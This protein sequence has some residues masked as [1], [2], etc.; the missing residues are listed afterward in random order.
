M[1]CC[2][3][4]VDRRGSGTGVG[5]LAGVGVGD[6]TD[7]RLA[8]GYATAFDLGSIPC[9]GDAIVLETGIATLGAG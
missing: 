4:V 6:S 2:N 7:E 9:D 5:E 3:L 8:I 1:P